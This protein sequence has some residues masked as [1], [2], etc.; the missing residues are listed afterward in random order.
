MKILGTIT[1]IAAVVVATIVN[2][3]LFAVAF[4]SSSLVI[5]GIWQD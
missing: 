2:P 4:L 1:A 5:A 3:F